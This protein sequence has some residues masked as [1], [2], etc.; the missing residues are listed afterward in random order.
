[1]CVCLLALGVWHANRLYSALHLLPSVASLTAPH[2][3]HYVIN[4]TIFG[5]K[6]LNI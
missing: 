6:L 1:V 4:G 5:K 2:S 3:L